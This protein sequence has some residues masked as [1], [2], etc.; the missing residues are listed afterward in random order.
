MA[1]EGR[2][3]LNDMKQDYIVENRPIDN[4]PLE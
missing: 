1:E 3:V 4:P 2:E